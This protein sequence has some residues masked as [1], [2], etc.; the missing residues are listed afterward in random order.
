MRGV[1]PDLLSFS[2]TFAPPSRRVFAASILPEPAAD[3]SDV[4]AEPG[5]LGDCIAVQAASETERH[6]AA[7]KYCDKRSMYFMASSL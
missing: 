3:M 5:L 1:S 4:M 6:V 7:R 2:F